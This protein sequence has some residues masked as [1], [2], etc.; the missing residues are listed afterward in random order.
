ML[1]CFRFLSFGCARAD[2]GIRE[3]GL[4]GGGGWGGELLWTDEMLR[5]F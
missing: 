2:R 1:D 4:L 5:H 3:G